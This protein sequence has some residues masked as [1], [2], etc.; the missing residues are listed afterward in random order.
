[1]KKLA[2]PLGYATALAIMVTSVFKFEHFPGAE[3][4]LYSTGLLLALYFPVYLLD[5]MSESS[6]GKISAANISAA[7]SA[8]LIDL[9]VTF[10]IWNWPGKD[11]LLIF[12]LTFFSL[13][14]VPLF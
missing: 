2:V 1:M 13:V 11:P 3:V 6:E 12:G 10:R 4:A 5:K 8:C 9:G 14:F 7:L